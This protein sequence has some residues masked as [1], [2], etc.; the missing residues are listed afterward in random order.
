M[1]AVIFIR[2]GEN[3]Y[4]KKGRLAGRLPGIHLN[5]KGIQQAQQLADQLSQVK[6]SAVYSSPLERAM[7]TAEPIAKAQNLEVVPRPGLL[8]VDYGEWQ[9]KSLK[10]LR[11]RK[12]WKAVQETPSLV[13]FPRGESF[14][15]A[16][17]RI[18]NEI[19]DLC[20]KHKT[21][22]MIVCVCHS[23]MIKL[24]V[25]YFIN[26]PLDQFQK[27]AVQPGSLTTLA[28]S[29][30]GNLLINLNVLPQHETS[31]GKNAGHP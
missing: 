26:L 24:A 15:E 5:D 6:L 29:S 18:A 25:A 12:L 11:R 14:T 20:S 23:D 8:E 16:Q 13:R 4:V 9:D 1:P 28:I 19:K 31:N 22:E 17:S 30:H 7:E 2:H 3:E 21:K 27:M 10:Q